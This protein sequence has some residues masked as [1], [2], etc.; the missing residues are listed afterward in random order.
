[1]SIKRI[2]IPLAI[3]KRIW[4]NLP[5]N[6]TIFQCEDRICRLPYGGEIELDKRFVAEV[7]GTSYIISATSLADTVAYFIEEL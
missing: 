3:F 4:P 5:N 6:T 7:D 1:M 2:C